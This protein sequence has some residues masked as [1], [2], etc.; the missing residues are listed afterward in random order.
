MMRS[1]SE[2]D[3]MKELKLNS[4]HEDK[5]LNRGTTDPKNQLFGEHFV[6]DCYDVDLETCKI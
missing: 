3:S 5:S 2:E 6:I 1:L 4:N